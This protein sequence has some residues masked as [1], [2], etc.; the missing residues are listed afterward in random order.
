[1]VSPNLV[2][3]LENT[4]LETTMNACFLGD[5]VLSLLIYLYETHTLY[6]LEDAE[7]DPCGGAAPA[8]PEG[9]A[10]SG[11]CTSALNLALV[12][13]AYAFARVHGKCKCVC[14]CVCGWVCGCV[15]VCVC[16]CVRASLW[17]GP[18]VCGCFF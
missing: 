9:R 4:S 2:D 1:M 7:M 11:G 6:T 3:P 12:E 18:L 17:G 15:C 14:V 8:T 13:C 16:V 5:R 10:G